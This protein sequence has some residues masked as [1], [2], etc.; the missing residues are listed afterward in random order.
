MQEEVR[1]ESQVEMARILHAHFPTFSDTIRQ[2]S[3]GFC[4]IFEQATLA[5]NTNLNQVAGVGYGKSL[6][7]LIK[8]YAKKG[9]PTNTSEIER[10]LLSS[11]I[12]DYIADPAIR[13]SAI[14]AAWLRND[15][16]HYTRKFITKDVQDLKSIIA[17]TVQ[18]IESA[19]KHKKLEASVGL[20]GKDMRGGH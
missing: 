16:T 13:E 6:E 9:Q 1:R 11:C 5:E 4:E 10:A 7:F 14:L 3:P 12:R 15:E 2:I 8:D 19:E 20:F 18:L 17:L